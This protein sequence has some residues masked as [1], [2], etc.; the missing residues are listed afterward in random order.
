MIFREKAGFCFVP[1]WPA[2]RRRASAPSRCILSFGCHLVKQVGS[3]WNVVQNPSSSLPFNRFIW[4]SG[5]Y[6]VKSKGTISHIFWGFHDVSWLC[7]ATVCLYYGKYIIQ[8]RPGSMMR[9]C[10]VGDLNVLLQSSAV[11]TVP[12]RGMASNYWVCIL[13]RWLLLPCW[14]MTKSSKLALARVLL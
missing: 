14:G 12:F 6:I 13:M 2:P 4:D 10:D 8:N 1:G 5:L 9:V 11:D 3:I 7:Q